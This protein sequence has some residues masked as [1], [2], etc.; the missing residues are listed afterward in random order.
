[1][2]I[3]A[4]AGRV[5]EFMAEVLEAGFVEAAFEERAR[6][7]AGGSMALEVDEVA[8]LITILGAGK[9]G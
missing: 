7:N 5:A 9:S 2:R 6:V 1:M 4:E 3:A 8:G